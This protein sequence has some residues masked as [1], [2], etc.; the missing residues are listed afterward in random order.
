M[1]ASVWVVMKLPAHLGALSLQGCNVDCKDLDI[2]TES[3]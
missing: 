3:R 2:H 1:S